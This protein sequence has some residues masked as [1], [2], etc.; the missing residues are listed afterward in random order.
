MKFS[1]SLRSK[2]DFHPILPIVKQFLSSLDLL[3]FIWSNISFS[4]PFPLV[5]LSTHREITRRKTCRNLA[6]K[7]FGARILSRP[8]IYCDW[9]LIFVGWRCAQNFHPSFTILGAVP[10]SSSSAPVTNV[11]HDETIEKLTPVT[12]P[13]EE[14]TFRGETCK[15]LEKERRCCKLNYTGATTR[16]LHVNS[17]S[18]DKAR[19]S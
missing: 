12:T 4:L 19:L 6:A 13:T 10:F 2:F 5:C 15:V 8:V 3:P 14:I 18:F 7:N 17:I 1:V 9:A 11:N 16:G